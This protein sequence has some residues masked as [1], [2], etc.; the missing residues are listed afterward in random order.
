[1]LT[2]TL[3][4]I[5]SFL[6]RPVSASS[7]MPPWASTCLLGPLPWQTI[8]IAPAFVACDSH[9][10]AG[11]SQNWKVPIDSQASVSHGPQLLNISEY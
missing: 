5:R 8:V 4:H 11:K 3:A 2:R 1:M 10:R 9:H 6:Q 7:S